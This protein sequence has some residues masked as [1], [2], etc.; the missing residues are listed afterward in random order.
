M[1]KNNEEVS[2][3]K[4]ATPPLFQSEAEEELILFAIL[5]SY[6]TDKN[7]YYQS[8]FPYKVG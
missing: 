8:V 4:I 1:D 3:F 7:K 2:E 5:D 6:R